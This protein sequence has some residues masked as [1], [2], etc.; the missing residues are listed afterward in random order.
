[1][2]FFEKINCNW[3]RLTDFGEEGAWRVRGWKLKKDVW[4]VVKM[5]SIVASLVGV[6]GR[7]GWVD[8]IF[9][10]R[11]LSFLTGSLYSNNNS[12]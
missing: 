6:E 10:V 8:C 9:M 1:M 4:I 12:D 2:F 3:Y 7:Q 5:L 11:V